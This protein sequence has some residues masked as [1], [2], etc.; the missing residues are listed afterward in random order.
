[1]TIDREFFAIV[2]DLVGT[3]TELIDPATGHI[4]AYA[5]SDLWGRTTW[6]GSTD[7]QLRLPGQFYDPETG[8][9]YNFFRIYDP[10]S[11]RYISRD[12]LGL[13]PSPNPHSYPRNP[14][15]WIDPLGLACR[16][17]ANLYDGSGGI[18][19]KLTDEGILSFVIERGA[20]TPSGRDMFQEMV[21][22]FGRE[23]ITGIDAKWVTEMPTNLDKYNE[24]IRQG[25]SPEQA[26]LATFTGK[27]A[28]ELGFTN[29][30][31]Y[32]LMGDSGQYT[33]IE[34]LFS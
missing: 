33:N 4:A 32:K 2:T 22:H 26:A 18:L 5:T 12:P 29:V 17:Y 30:H 3:P 25:M 34:V 11:G 13:L 20:G 27:R 10:D 23:N 8:L 31:V 1:M 16:E 28:S 19:G 15:T 7:T 9:H 14:T 24:L 21:D 6:R